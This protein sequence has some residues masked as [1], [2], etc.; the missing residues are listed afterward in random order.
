[1]QS[2]RAGSRD[3]IKSPSPKQLELLVA[4]DTHW[5]VR[6]YGPCHLDLARLLRVSKTA[7]V[8][9][10]E[11]A[12]KNGWIHRPFRAARAVRLTASG[13]SA[14]GGVVRS[15]PVVDRIANARAAMRC[16]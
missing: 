13:H 7:I 16:A 12:T 4:I 15:L 11:V 14:I 3:P 6:G 5:R 2:W 9:R 1:M 10:I 8:L